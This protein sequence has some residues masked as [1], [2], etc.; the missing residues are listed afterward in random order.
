MVLCKSRF[1]VVL[2]ICGLTSIER[3][4]GAQGFTGGFKADV[5]WTGETMTGQTTQQEVATVHSSYTVG[6]RSLIPMQSRTMTRT[7]V[8]N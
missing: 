1:K 8:G 3:A 5:T 7:N 4:V 6:N 2:P